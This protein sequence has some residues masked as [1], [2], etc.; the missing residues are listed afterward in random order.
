[1]QLTPF[2]KVVDR[3]I[4]T[5]DMS[6]SPLFQVLFVLQNKDA[7][8]GEKDRGLTDITISGYEFDTATSKF[9]LTCSVSESDHGISLEINYCT[10]LFDKT[11]IDRMLFHYQELLVS[12]VDNITQPISGLSIL[13]K[14]EEHQLLD[15]FNSTDVGYPK[16]KTLIDLFTEEV[17]R[18]PNAIALVFEDKK[19]S[20][21]ELEQR[22]NQLG[23]YLREQGVQPDDLVGICLER[24]LE[25]LV[26]IL[27]I[28]KSGGAYV[29][30]DPEYPSDRIDYMLTDAGIGLVLSSES[31]SGVIKERENLSVLCLDKDWDVLSGYPI[32]ALSTV[33]SGSNLAYVIYTSGSTGIPKGVLITH[34]NVVRLFKNE[35]SL[36]DFGSTDVWTLFHSFCFDFSVWEMYGA[37]LHG[38]RLVIVPKVFTK[39]AI[40]FRELLIKEGVTVLNQTPGSF[41]ALQEEFLSG[42]LAHSLRYVIFGGEALNS[43]YLSQWK[44]SYPDC[45]LINMYGITETTVHVTYKEI[46]DSD[47]K[48]LISNIGSSIPTLCCYIVDAHLNL[49]PIG[50]EGELCV[51]G[52]GVARGYLNRE[53][54]TREKFIANPFK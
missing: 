48:S 51:S 13:T 46:L 16:D 23:H 6:M 5:R 30:I 27:G 32:T 18:T 11:T 44:S 29:P 47:T 36:Y 43:T 31:S 21:E 3:V 4:T 42:H 37:L 10:A 7:N 20:Y 8:F 54:L 41:Y 40:S 17:K 38:G 24:S 22:S 52:A 53:E 26:G 45:K 28:L 39:D 15:I 2:E 35:S 25:M 50:V 9:D 49:V 14:G 19:L 12:I 33:V 1:H 34:E